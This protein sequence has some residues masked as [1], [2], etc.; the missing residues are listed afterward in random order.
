MNIKLSIIAGFVLISALGGCD[1]SPMMNNTPAPTSTETGIEI[2]GFKAFATF[3]GKPRYIIESKEARVIEKDNYVEMDDIHLS[4]F[5]EN[6]DEQ[7]GTLTAD[8][9]IYYFRDN[10][11]RKHHT[12]DIELTGNV[13]FQ[14]TDGTLL[15]TSEVHYDNITEKIYSRSDF[16]KRKAS[17]D[18]TL[19]IKGK[20]FITDKSLRHWEDTGATMTLEAHTSTD[21][22]EP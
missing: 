19:V 9:G 1:S 17:K 7:A 16:E 10:P 20:S 21:S 2:I 5:K 8:K 6:T 4:F 22:K 13:I 11:E 3:E 15:K 18:Q 12:N 14:T